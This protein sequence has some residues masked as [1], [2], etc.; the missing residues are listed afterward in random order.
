MSNMHNQRYTFI[1]LLA[2]LLGVPAGR[3]AAQ[4]VP[5]SKQATDPDDRT[6]AEKIGTSGGHNG[7]PAGEW[8]WTARDTAFC[9]LPPSMHVY[10]TEDSLEGRP[11]IAYYVSVPLKDKSL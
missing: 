8:T 10:R 9:P 3:L 4:G 1:L 11:S 5:P 6:P 2:F 7:A